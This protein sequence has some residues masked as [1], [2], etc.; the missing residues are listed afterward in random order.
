MTKLDNDAAVVLARC[1]VTTYAMTEWRTAKRAALDYVR[2]FGN[3]RP[4]RCYLRSMADAVLTHL[5]LGLG[6][7]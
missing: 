7:I 4:P 1:N 3:V 5:T 2:A 6:A